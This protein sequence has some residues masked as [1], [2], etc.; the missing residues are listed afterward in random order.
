MSKVI[1]SMV[2][3][4]TATATSDAE[5]ASIVECIRTGRWRGPIE[6]IRA[7]FSRVLQQTGDLKETKRAV[8]LIKKNLPAIMFSGRFSSREKPADGK[9]LAHSGLWCADLDD[10]GESL[11]QVR[12]KLMASPYLRFKF[13]S[14]T[15][16]GLKA[17]FRVPAS[18]EKH[19]DS[20]HTVQQHVLKL[21]GV[22]IDPACSDVGRLCFVSYDP[23]TFVNEEAI[24]MPL[25][26][27]SSEEKT[28][29]PEASQADVSAPDGGVRHTIAETLLGDIRWEDEHSGFC[30]CPGKHLH[31]TGNGDRDCQVKLDN[32]PTIYCFHSHCRGILEGVNHQLRSLVGKAEYSSRAKPGSAAS[33]YIGTGAF[34]PVWQEPK[35]LPAGL[36]VVPA[37]G[38]ACLPDTLRPWI[39][40]IAERMQCPPDFPAV[41]AIIALGSLIGRKIGIRPKRQDDWLVIGNLWGCIVGRP[42]LMKTPAL[43]HAMAPLRRLVAKALEKFK[44]EQREHQVSTMLEEQGAKLAERKITG[45][46]KKGD[47]Q[48]AR[49]EAQAIVDKEPDEPFCRRYET[50]DPTIEKLGELLAK[51]PMGLLLFR[52]ELIGFLRSLDRDGHESDRANFLEMWAGTGNF[53]SDRILR[54]TVSS[55]AVIS[56]LGG[57]PPDALMAYVREAVRGGQGADGLLQRFQLLVWPDNSKDWQNVD[58]LPDAEA[59]NRAFEIFEYLDSLTPESVGA[60]ISGGIPF[61]HFT[62]DAQDR[63]DVWRAELERKL[64]GGEEHPAFEAQLSKYRK[65][66]PALALLTHLAN[67]DTGPVSLSALSKALLWGTYLEAHARRIYSIVQSPDIA[68]ARELAKHL[69]HGDLSERFTLREA[70][71]KGWTGLGTRED[72]EGATEILSDLGWIRAV[73][74]TGRATGRPASPTFEIHPKVLKS[75][76]RELPEPPKLGSGSSGSDHRLEVE[77][78]CAS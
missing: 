50:N 48:A 70:Y 78:N 45:H 63:F 75:A 14:P 44:L 54:G 38:F 77:K 72:A 43:E 32:V 24:E 49:A 27:I 11:A 4:A 62:P 1:V 20:F 9:L 8:A 23:D 47:E 61:V 58:R 56:I 30:V 19:A 51:N 64:R 36:P 18:A 31:T 15:D 6:K 65:L 67:R 74:D 71:R 34:E 59:K 22:E 40:D 33:E 60:D 42:G 66:I 16:N 35:P 55:P 73:A 39:Q 7:E 13:A 53:T 2:A 68:A 41:G 37:F 10:L 69:Q 26:A 25:L 17:I 29:P 46:L 52:D 57:I 28:S 21:T 12:T 5:V 76:R 3:D